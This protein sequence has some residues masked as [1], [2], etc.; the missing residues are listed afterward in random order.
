MCWVHLTYYGCESCAWRDTKSPLKSQHMPEG[1]KKINPQR[2]VERSCE[3]RR[4]IKG[5]ADCTL[6]T[7]WE[8]VP[9]A[10]CERCAERRGDEIARTR[11]REQSERSSWSPQQ[12][13]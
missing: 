11:S 5:H 10:E 2:E 12:M 3:K 1:L 8:Y 9:Y 13:L 4:N 6:S 7:D